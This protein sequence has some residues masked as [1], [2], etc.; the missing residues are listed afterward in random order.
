MGFGAS[1]KGSER[2]K[3]ELRVEQGCNVSLGKPRHGPI[4]KKLEHELTHRVVSP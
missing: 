4:H 2:S 3:M 1:Q